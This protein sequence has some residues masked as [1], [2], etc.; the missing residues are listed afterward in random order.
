MQWI[1][2][3]IGVTIALFG[4]MNVAK[5]AV[6]FDDEAL[7]LAAV[8]GAVVVEDFSNEP[9]PGNSMSPRTFDGSGIVVEANGGTLQSPI[10]TIVSDELR[11]EVSNIGFNV[12][13]EEMIF[14]L[15]VP[16]L[17]IAFDFRRVNNGAAATNAFL[18]V[19]GMNVDLLGLADGF[20]GVDA[21]GFAG[22]I[23][24]APVTEFKFITD[25][26]TS[27]GLDQFEIDDLS[28]VVAVPEPA[29]FAL[30]G[31]GLIGLGLSRR[32]RLV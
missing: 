21:F 18:S 8:N 20:F 14:T 19:G 5:A 25:P 16:T 3:A 32:R 2:K 24:D 22:V 26:L 27:G 12:R 11:L 13:V 30:I 7:W 15:P 17:A 28:F 10:L 29:G 1:V 23:L 9:N 31:V 6:I 4:L